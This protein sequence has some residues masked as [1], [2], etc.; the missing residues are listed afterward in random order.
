M[1]NIDDLKYELNKAKEEGTYISNE[2]IALAIKE[3]LEPDD[4]GEI[5]KRL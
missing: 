3:V 1:N 5:K 2:D 4:V